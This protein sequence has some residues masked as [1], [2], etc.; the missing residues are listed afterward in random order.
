M[1]QTTQEQHAELV[2]YTGHNECLEIRKATNVKQVWDS[3][4]DYGVGLALGRLGFWVGD[5]RGREFVG[6]SENDVREYAER[7]LDGSLVRFV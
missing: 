3:Y 7:F 6:R 2:G 1:S 4:V 5:D